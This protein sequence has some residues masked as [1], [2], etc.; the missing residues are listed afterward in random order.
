MQADLATLKERVLAAA[1]T[2]DIG[3]KVA[4]VTLEPARDDEGSDFLRVVVQIKDVETSS[5]E[6]LEAFEA[7]LERIEGTVAEIDERYPSVRFAEAA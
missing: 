6:A 5:H 1:K 2:S 3:S 4:G 7:L